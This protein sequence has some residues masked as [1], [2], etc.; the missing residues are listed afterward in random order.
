MQ[1]SSIFDEALSLSNLNKWVESNLILD[2][3]SAD[4]SDTVDIHRLYAKN[5]RHIGNYD[6][7]IDRLTQL[8]ALKK[9]DLPAMLERAICEVNLGHKDVALT[10]LEYLVQLAPKN[11]WA[12]QLW[13]RLKVEFEPPK[14]IIEE[15]CR[16][17][18]I[19]EKLSDFNMLL[20]Q[21]RSRLFA[22][23]DPE[24]LMVL[25]SHN[26]LQLQ[27]SSLSSD[28]SN[29]RGIYEHFESLGE[30]CEFGF[31]QRAEGAEPIGLFRWSGIQPN[32]LIAVIDSKLND[33][34][35]PEHYSL[36]LQPSSLYFLNDSK[37]D[38]ITHTHIQAGFAPVDLLL[39]KMLQRQMFLKRKFFSEIRIGTKIFV[40]KFNNLPDEALI[41]K[42]VKTLQGIGITK[43][44]I[45]M[46]ANDKEA[47][48]STRILSNGAMVG[49]LSKR[50]PDTPYSEWNQ[51]VQTA[52]T[53]F[54]KS[55]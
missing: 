22:L 10:E 23:H 15:L 2:G 19:I 50:Y 11:H 54:E 51:I 1:T 53:F 26:V 32:Q 5:Y 49:F 42:L 4:Q 12:L 40:Y 20:E 31:A 18:Q 44:L 21:V 46:K 27:A 13:L 7:A 36:N 52:Y 33:F 28:G 9:N 16:L 3:I 37:Y 39:N 35:A 14:L 45:G 41:E 8:L 34:D 55:H 25:D 47:P 30:D 48:G 17:K 6:K 43:I 24:S 38:T 29:L